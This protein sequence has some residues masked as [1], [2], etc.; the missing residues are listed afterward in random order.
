MENFS[1]SKK[2]SP[3]AGKLGFGISAATFIAVW[4]I[5]ILLWYNAMNSSILLIILTYAIGSVLIGAALVLSILGLR[6]ASLHSLNQYP[7]LA[8]IVVSVA[9]IISMIMLVYVETS[10]QIQEEALSIQLP[11]TDELNNSPK[12]YDAW[13][14]LDKDGNV[15]CYREGDEENAAVIGDLKEEGFV[16]K[17]SDWLK[18]NNLEKKSTIALQADP[19]ESTFNDVRTVLEAL[20]ISGYPYIVMQTQTTDDSEE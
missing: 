11:N 8:G 2:E 3:A 9:S 6:K 5:L 20:T 15:K 10:L 13:V 14:V 17:L 4:V 1:N 16:N 19:E 7:A 18:A 12:S